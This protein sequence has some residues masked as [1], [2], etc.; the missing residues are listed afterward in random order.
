MR[1]GRQLT[2]PRADD[3]WLGAKARSE[4]RTTRSP[5]GAGRHTG[6]E[7]KR[8][9]INLNPASFTVRS[10]PVRNSSQPGSSPH[11]ILRN[12]RGKKNKTRTKAVRQTVSCIMKEAQG[13]V[14]KDNWDLQAVQVY[15]MNLVPKGR[16][17]HWYFRRMRKPLKITC[18]PPFLQRDATSTRSPA[19]HPLADMQHSATWGF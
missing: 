14:S 17:P 12:F 1:W 19:P 3:L 13:Y 9:A 11:N 10:L 16:F 5:P 4:L 18:S 2:K 6:S 15:R 8:Y 7:G